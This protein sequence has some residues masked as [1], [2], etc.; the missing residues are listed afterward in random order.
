LVRE[1]TGRYFVRYLQAIGKADRIQ[2]LDMD[3]D[4][5]IADFGLTS[6]DVSYAS[7][8]TVWARF[9]APINDNQK[10]ALVAASG[11]Q[12]EVMERYL[13]SN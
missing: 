3:E 10:A 1:G 2:K 9:S 11:G 6:D 12:N 7:D 13:L 8:G 5:S 4:D